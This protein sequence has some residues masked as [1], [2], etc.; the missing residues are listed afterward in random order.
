NN[1][2]IR[3]TRERHRSLAFLKRAVHHADRD[4]LVNLYKKLAGFK[5][6]SCAKADRVVKTTVITKGMIFVFICPPVFGIG[7]F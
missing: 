3:Q 1:T 6:R 7:A 2:H 4:L 5:K